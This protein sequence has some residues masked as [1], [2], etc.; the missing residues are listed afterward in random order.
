MRT[1]Q[2]A[3][4]SA[5]VATC[6]EIISRSTSPSKSFSANKMWTTYIYFSQN[7]GTNFQ[8]ILCWLSSWFLVWSDVGPKVPNLMVQSFSSLSAA[9]THC[10]V[11]LRSQRD[12]DWWPKE[13]VWTFPLTRKIL[14]LR[15]IFQREG[16]YNGSRGEHA[17]TSAWH[18]S[19]QDW[20][21]K[22]T[23]NAIMIDYIECYQDWWHWM[24]S[25]VM[26]LSAIRID[27]IEC[28]Q[29]WLH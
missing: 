14:N 8:S 18:S 22:I 4:L 19:H 29:D 12:G 21:G 27:D 26:T 25:G 10:A 7:V 5:P 3:T 28:Y 17:T 9:N 24:L 1:G 23:L 15:N 11:T 13:N 2:Q 20:G 6:L 16:R